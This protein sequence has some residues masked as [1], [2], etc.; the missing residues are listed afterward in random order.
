MIS[1][2]N[3]QLRVRQ[4]IAHDLKRFNHQLEPFVGSPFSECEDAV[5]WIASA[6]E[7]GIFRTA[8]QNAMRAH[9]N[10]VVTVL[11]VKD[12]AISR[13]KHRHRIREQEHPRRKCTR[14]P[15]SARIPNPCIFQIHRI[16]QVVQC[17]VGVTTA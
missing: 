15:V 12:L 8:R 3:H 10:I 7:I 11:F 2:S 17:H 5:L 6:G 4:G 13:H 16:H 9:V 14:L 1:T